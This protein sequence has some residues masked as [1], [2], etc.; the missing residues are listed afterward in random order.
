MKNKDEK[1]IQ[2]EPKH[3][4]FLCRGVYSPPN[5]YAPWTW[6]LVAWSGSTGGT[7]HSKWL[8]VAGSEITG[9]TPFLEVTSGGPL[10]PPPIRSD[11]WWLDLELQGK[12][13]SNINKLK[14]FPSLTP[15]F[16]D[17][18]DTKETI[19]IISI[20]NFSCVFRFFYQNF[21]KFTQ[22][23]LQKISLQWKKTRELWT[24]IL[25]KQQPDILTIISPH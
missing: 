10:T 23:W 11:I 14:T 20:Q 13:P 9:G 16:V 2:K 3:W 17:S 1:T 22:K 8:L 21:V 12:G 24:P 6:H 5:P 19:P 4:Y 7:F 15:P 18:N 25:Q